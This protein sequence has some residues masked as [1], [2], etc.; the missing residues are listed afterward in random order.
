[1]SIFYY[2]TFT[3]RLSNIN[4][5]NN[6]S[7]A[8]IQRSA[9][10]RKK[11]KV[12]TKESVFLPPR[13]LTKLARMQDIQNVR[14][15]DMNNHI[16]MGLSGNYFW[17]REQEWPI[18]KFWECEW[19]LH[20]QLLET[21]TGMEISLLIFGKEDGR[22]V[23]LGWLGTGMPPENW[24]IWDFFPET[25][26]HFKSHFL[27]QTYQQVFCIVTIHE[28]DG[29]HNTDLFKYFMNRQAYKRQLA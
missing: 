4:S 13:G 22:P 26:E 21:G 29:T 27:G 23:F 3:V 15:D 20:S 28:C 1:M 5:R 9:G 24:G 14:D 8:A 19:K 10:L 18:P 2:S 12:E 25:K 11:E 6:C 17:V 16:G 7:P